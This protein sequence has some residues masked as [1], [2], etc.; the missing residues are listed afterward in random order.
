MVKMV[1]KDWHNRYQ[2]AILKYLLR[3]SRGL[4]IASE[5]F[6]VTLVS[7]DNV[8]SGPTPVEPAMDDV[9]NWA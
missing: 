1:R 8:P 5:A 2:K 6:P 7:I 4:E 3:R 9:I